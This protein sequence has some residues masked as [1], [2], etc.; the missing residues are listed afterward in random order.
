M[1][2]LPFISIIDCDVFVQN[3]I[4]PTTGQWIS[5]LNTDNT[6][7]VTKVE[8]I[9][10]KQCCFEEDTFDT[11]TVLEIPMDFDFDS[12]SCV[13]CTGESGVEGSHV[14]SVTA[15]TTTNVDNT[16][17]YVWSVIRNNVVVWTDSGTTTTICDLARDQSGNEKLAAN[18]V[19]TLTVTLTNGVKVTISKTV[20]SAQS[21]IDCFIL[22][23]VDSKVVTYTTPY[24]VSSN[25]IKVDTDTYA[26][27]D[28]VWS[29][30]YIVYYTENS[31]NKTETTDKCYLIDCDTT[32]K[33]AASAVELYRTDKEFFIELGLLKQALDAAIDCQHCCDACDLFELY[34]TAINY[35]K[36][37]PCNC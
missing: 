10:K 15:G 4:D 11:T 2:T 25:L 28:G 7:T 17:D 35:G 8:L 33:L 27:K 36:L 12:L 9:G 21:N 19:I 23:T 37:S 30:R 31:V 26:F 6:I 13:L 22:F 16:V 20:S 32:C 3:P 29:L 14:L 18:D 24:T 5:T 34:E 1:F